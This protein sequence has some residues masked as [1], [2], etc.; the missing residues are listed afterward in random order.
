MKI[1]AHRGASAVTPENT[2]KSFSRAL[3][4][5]VDGI[6]LDV[7]LTRDA[8]PVVIHD[9]SVDRTTNGSGLVSQIGFKQLSG[10][11]AGNGEHIPSLLQA[12]NLIGG[13]AHTY[14][15]LK[16][17]VEGNESA[18]IQCVLDAKCMDNVTFISFN[19]KSIDRIKV[20]G[21]KCKLGYSY[22]SSIPKLDGAEGIDAVMCK[23]N[24]IGH[25]LGSDAHRRGMEIIAWTVDDAQKAIELAKI[26][27]DGIITNDPER[28]M[29]VLR[30]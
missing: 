13:K 6:E 22:E 10:L 29:R 1:I 9:T 30:R 23:Y 25:E 11:D 5:G 27:V 24:L 4:A 7:Q 20:L 19:H 18:V 2:P 21:L 28:M 16:E 17:S 3:E 8:V 12:L 26:G 14:V 15:E